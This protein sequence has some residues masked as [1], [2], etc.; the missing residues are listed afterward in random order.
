MVNGRVKISQT[1]T[2]DSEMKMSFQI[3]RFIDERWAQGAAAR[4][5]KFRKGVSISLSDLEFQKWH[6]DIAILVLLR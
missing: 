1:M 2:N 5:R 4:T 6:L 3:D